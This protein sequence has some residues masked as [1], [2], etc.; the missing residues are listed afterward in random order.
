[1]K[2]FKKLKPSNYE[3]HVYGIYNNL[4]IYFRVG[5]LMILIKVQLYLK[6][7][8]SRC[9]FEFIFVFKKVKR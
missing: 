5:D 1:M 9:S 4:Q 6:T 7:F 3:T 8:I 2:K